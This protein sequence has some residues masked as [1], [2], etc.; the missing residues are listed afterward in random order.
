LWKFPI[1]EGKQGWLFYGI[2]PYDLEGIFEL[3]GD[4]TDLEKSLKL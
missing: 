2:K 3:T 1:L 4:T